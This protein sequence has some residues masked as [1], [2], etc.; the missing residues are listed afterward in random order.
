MNTAKSMNSYL[1]VPQLT[2]TLSV[3]KQRH[4]D[5]KQIR[6]VRIEYKMLI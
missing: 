4:C 1:N 3:D 6:T 2:L 5:R